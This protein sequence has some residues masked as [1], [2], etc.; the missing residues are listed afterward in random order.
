MIESTCAQ[1]WLPPRHILV[2]RLGSHKFYIWIAGD[3]RQ[4]THGAGGFF[5]VRGAESGYRDAATTTSRCVGSN[6][7]GQ[8]DL[9][10]ARDLQSS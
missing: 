8:P 10:P 1:T 5:M 3:T 4:D 9:R 6:K 2:M 7:C